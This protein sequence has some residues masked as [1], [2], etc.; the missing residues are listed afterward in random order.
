MRMAELGAS[1]RVVSH[2]GPILGL[3]A[4]DYHSFVASAASDGVCG[5]SNT[6]RRMKRG[7][8]AVRADFGGAS[9]EPQVVLVNLTD[10]DPR[11]GLSTGP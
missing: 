11:T 2:N 6:I 4:S 3:A 8:H 10:C 9:G 7:N 5:I 1:T